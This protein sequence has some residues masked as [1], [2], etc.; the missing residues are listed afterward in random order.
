MRRMTFLLAPK[1]FNGWIARNLREKSHS[2][3]LGFQKLKLLY[4]LLLPTHFSPLF[5]FEKTT[6]IYYFVRLSFNI[7]IMPIMSLSLD[8]RHLAQSRPSVSII[9]LLMQHMSH[10][11]MLYVTFFISHVVLRHPISVP[12]KTCKL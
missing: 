7:S 3:S 2:L 4:L 9:S 10:E 12:R 8:F 6:T 11:Y 5:K 1:E